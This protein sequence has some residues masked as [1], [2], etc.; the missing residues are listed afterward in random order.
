MRYAPSLQRYAARLLPGDVHRAEDIVQQALLRAWQ[1][2]TEL[3]FQ[4]SIRPW[5]FRVVRNLSVDWYRRQAAR[6][7]EVSEDSVDVVDEVAQELLEDVLRRGV[8]GDILRPLSKQ[9]REV[10]IQLY[11]VGRTQL[12]VAEALG[13]SQGTVKSRA[14][15]ALAQIRETMSAEG[16]G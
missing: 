3:V 8:I 13:I 6:P 9:H 15:Y 11:Y 10:L 5:L 14:H 2:H 1:H 7:I 4:P 12:E 16:R